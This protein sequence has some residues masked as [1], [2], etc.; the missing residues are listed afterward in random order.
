MLAPS[1][2]T[3]FTCFTGT[4]VQILT[5]LRADFGVSRQWTVEGCVLTLMPGLYGSIKAVAVAQVCSLLAL[6]AQKKYKV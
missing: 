6:P 3:E 2:G 5:H 4:K 1:A